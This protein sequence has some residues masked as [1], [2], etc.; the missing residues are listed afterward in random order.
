MPSCR[1]GT[2][3][4][5]GALHAIQGHK[6]VLGHQS[7]V[8]TQQR[9]Q[10]HSGV[11]AGCQTGKGGRRGRRE[12]QAAEESASCT[13][14]GA[15]RAAHSLATRKRASTHAPDTT[16]W[17]RTPLHGVT[18]HDNHTQGTQH[19]AYSTQYTA[20]STQHTAPQDTP[21]TY[22]THATR[23]PALSFERRRRRGRCTLGHGRTPSRCR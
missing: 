19:T 17:R 7:V 2:H 14:V 4:V 5:H 23:L 10:G 21:N 12:S 22:H 8:Q 9:S 13:H 15:G 1:A 11:H 18:R 6:G 3:I 20:P 16:T